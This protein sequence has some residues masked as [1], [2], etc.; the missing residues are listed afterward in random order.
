MDDA[1]CNNM[2]SGIH[3]T[4]F[5]FSSYSS[6]LKSV[7]GISQVF[8]LCLVAGCSICWFNTVCFVL[9]I[10]NFPAANRA[11]ALSL[12]VS[13]NG[14]T[15]TL[16]TLLANAIKPSD[17]TLYL[18]LN[19]LVPLFMSVVVLIP[20]FRQPPPH[21]PRPDAICEDSR[22]FLYLNIMAIIT[23]LYLLPLNSLPSSAAKARILFAG[24][25]ILLAL[26]LCL[27]GIVCARKWG[28]NDIHSGFCLDDSSVNLVRTR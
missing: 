5:D 2:A 10:R 14:I 12:T 8:L 9:C 16:Y 6:D 20:V 17:D 21:S 13:F 26:P 27:P 23:G 15:A 25:I 19:A 1:D 4:N 24:A 28:R 22:I 11:L 18:L 3:I 7:L